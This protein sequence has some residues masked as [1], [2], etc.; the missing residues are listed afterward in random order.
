VGLRISGAVDL[1]ES[2]L[3]EVWIAF[4]DIAAIIVRLLLL[5]RCF[6]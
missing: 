6:L 2:M 1:A 3:A 5:R 4:L